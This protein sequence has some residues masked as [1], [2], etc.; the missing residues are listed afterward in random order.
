MNTTLSQNEPAQGIYVVKIYM[1]HILFTE[2]LKHCL[3]LVA[4]PFCV[5]VPCYLNVTACFR[6]VWGAHTDISML[7]T[8]NPGLENR[9]YDRRDSLR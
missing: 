9:S 2:A 1:I 3:F 4:S 6:M 5:H 7:Y 8:D